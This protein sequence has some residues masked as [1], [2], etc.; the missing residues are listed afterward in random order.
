MAAVMKTLRWLAQKPKHDRTGWMFSHLDFP[1]WF[2]PPTSFN[3]S[4]PNGLLPPPFTS[5]WRAQPVVFKPV[6][7]CWESHMSMRKT[8]NVYFGLQQEKLSWMYTRDDISVNRPQ[9]AAAHFLLV[10][11]FLNRL[12]LWGKRHCC[13]YPS[14]LYF[15]SVPRMS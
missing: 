14:C 4:G 1:C 3:P 9:V 6:R 10:S 15:P 2:W 7:L 11:L 8:C 5:V 13:L 12:C